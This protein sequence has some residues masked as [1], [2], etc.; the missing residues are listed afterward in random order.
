MPK[1]LAL[2]Q[3]QKN[4]ALGPWHIAIYF[5]SVQGEIYSAL[6]MRSHMNEFHYIFYFAHNLFIY[7]S[8]IFISSKNRIELFRRALQGGTALWG[9]PYS[10]HAVFWPFLTPSPPLHA[11]ARIWPT[12]PL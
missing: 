3:A 12:P 2:W 1:I 8:I 10:A 11:C 9:R 6:Q 7:S 4:I 5:L